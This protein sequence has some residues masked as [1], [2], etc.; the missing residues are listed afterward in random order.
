LRAKYYWDGQEPPCEENDENDDSFGDWQDVNPDLA[1]D[2]RLVI[3]DSDTPGGRVDDYYC[4]SHARVNF[5]E[6]VVF[7]FQAQVPER[8]SRKMDWMASFDMARSYD[9]TALFVL[10]LPN[11]WDLTNEVRSEQH[12]PD[13]GLIIPSEPFLLDAN[14]QD[15]TKLLSL[16]DDSHVFSEGTNLIG[17][18]GLQKDD[19]VV[20]MYTWVEETDTATHYSDLTRCKS[21][22]IEWQLPSAGW[23]FFV[24]NSAG[25]SNHIEGFEFE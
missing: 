25:E 11:D 21:F 13:L 20:S 24:T 7:H 23:A 1:P 2:G 6:H 4:F 22:P 14:T 3:V 15:G 19:R 8:C 10:G 9:K 5:V 17:R 12:L 18:F 16:I